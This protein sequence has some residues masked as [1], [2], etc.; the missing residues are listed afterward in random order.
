[1]PC[2]DVRD[3]ESRDYNFERKLEAK[4]DELAQYLCATMR[5]LETLGYDLKANLPGEPVAWW[6]NHKKLDEERISRE[7][8]KLEA[9][10]QTAHGA[11]TQF[12]IEIEEKKAEL[13]ALRGTKKT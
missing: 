11:F 10:A 6:E 2:S 4:I 1:M 9:R 8:K 12:L 7:L 5:R 13:S 3:Y